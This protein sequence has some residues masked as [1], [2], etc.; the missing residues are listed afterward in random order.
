MSWCFLY[1]LTCVRTLLRILVPLLVGDVFVG[2]KEQ[3]HLTL[4]IL[5]GNNVQKTP[6]LCTCRE[7]KY[8]VSASFPLKI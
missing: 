5:N 1:E 4:L 6:E 3:N 2:H 7:N 8:K